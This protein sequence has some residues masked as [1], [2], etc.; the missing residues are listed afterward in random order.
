MI[1]THRSGEPE[2]GGDLLTVSG[3]M[4]GLSTGKGI[5]LLFR[6]IKISI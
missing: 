6:K 2:E 3:S 4:I 1:I 5:K